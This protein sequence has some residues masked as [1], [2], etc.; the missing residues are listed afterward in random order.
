MYLSRYFLQ[1]LSKISFDLFFAISVETFSDNIMTFSSINF[2]YRAIFS[3]LFKEGNNLSVFDDVK[4]SSN[5]IT[6]VFIFIFLSRKS[7]E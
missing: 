4:V 3:S 2:G 7:H 5:N 6:T 1:D